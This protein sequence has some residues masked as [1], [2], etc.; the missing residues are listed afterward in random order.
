MVARLRL[1]RI[2]WRHVSSWNHTVLVKISTLDGQA[3]KEEANLLECSKWTKNFTQPSHFIPL[4]LI[5]MREKSANML[6]DGLLRPILCV[7]VSFCYL[8]LEKYME[9]VYI[10][11]VNFDYGQH[12]YF[13]DLTWLSLHRVLWLLSY[14]VSQTG[15][16]PRLI[17][18][19]SPILEYSA[20]FLCLF[21]RKLVGFFFFLFCFTYTFTYIEH[22]K[23]CLCNGL[24]DV[25]TDIALCMLTFRIS[26]SARLQV[27]STVHTLHREAHQDGA[28]T[29]IVCDPMI[30]WNCPLWCLFHLADWKLSIP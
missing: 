13:S 5:P 14:S 22:L 18:L 1:C 26:Y 9:Q 8:S 11:T 28:P 7:S 17:I 2:L 12:N 30:A 4:H 24:S 10:W 21:S 3:F 16:R 15:K 20:A 25:W 29:K 6:N 27:A 19:S 23:E